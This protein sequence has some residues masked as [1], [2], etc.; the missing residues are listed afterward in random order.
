M[1]AN[2]F[3]YSDAQP[4][5]GPRITPANGP[6][7]DRAEVTLLCVGLIASAGGYSRGDAFPDVAGFVV[8]SDPQTEPAGSGSYLVTLSGR[9]VINGP[10]VYSGKDAF[11]ASE[12]RTNITIGGT[13]Y[14]P[15]EPAWPEVDLMLNSEGFRQVIVGAAS[16]VGDVGQ[17]V[18]APQVGSFPTPPPN[19]WDTIANPKLNYPWGWVLA[20]RSAEPLI[21]GAYTDAGPWLLTLDYVYR[22][23]L[24]P[25]S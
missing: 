25:S 9:G 20:R 23:K 4:V 15:F 8:D 19:P 11:A 13:Q 5:N 6:Q 18:N 24:T 10:R 12:Q 2:Y 22:W 7:W 14:S 1:P 21:D 16:M 17:K 3:G